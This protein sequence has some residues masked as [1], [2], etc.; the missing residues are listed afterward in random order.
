MARDKQHRKGAGKKKFSII[1]DG[2]TELWY[3]QLMKQYESLP[4]DIMPEIPKRKSL[5]AQYETV[6]EN[7][8]HYDTVF[9]LIDYDAILKED[10]ETKK[11]QNS[12][13]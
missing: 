10:R 11:G 2:E 4:I 12:G 6:L 8:K 13:I 5:Q 7:A 1:V 3:F 9:W